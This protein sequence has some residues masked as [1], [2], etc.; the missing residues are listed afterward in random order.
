MFSVE[1]NAGRLLEIRLIAPVSVEDIL[2]TGERLVQLFQKH[3]GKLV[4]AGDITR[5]TVFPPDVAAKVLEVFRV[6]NPRLERSAILV[7]SS[8][9]FGLQIERLI[10]QAENPAR[11]CFHD[12]FELKAF[13]GTLLTREEHGRLAQ[14]LSER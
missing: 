6:D 7:S 9:V 3:P 2:I 11:R 1:V 8:A 13:L 10:S 14:F 5:A 12:P 4:S